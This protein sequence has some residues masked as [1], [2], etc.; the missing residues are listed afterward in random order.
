MVACN[1]NAGTVRLISALVDP[2]ALDTTSITDRI[3]TILMHHE[4]RGQI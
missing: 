4:M 2:D 3:I 1:G